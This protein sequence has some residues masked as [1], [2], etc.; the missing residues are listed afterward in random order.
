MIPP[1]SIP[2]PVTGRAPWR[3]KSPPGS[4]VYTAR[5]TAEARPQKRASLDSTMLPGFPWVAKR[6]VPR[7]ART[8][9]RTSRSVGSFKVFSDT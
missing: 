2:Q 1:M 6:K 7:T 3:F 8:I 5:A 4:T 9:A